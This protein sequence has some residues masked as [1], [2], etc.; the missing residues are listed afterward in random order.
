MIICSKNRIIIGLYKELT[1]LLTGI[2]L[3]SSCGPK[4]LFEEVNGEKLGIKF[5]NQVDQSEVFNILTFEHLYNGGGVAIDDFNND[6]LPDIFFTGNIVN[7]K[8]FLNRGKLE[9]EDISAEAGI[10]APQKWCSGIT[11][12]DINHDGWKDIYLS[13]T[14][15]GREESRRNLLFI[16]QGLNKQGIPEF[17]D[18]ADAYGIADDG[19]SVQSV[20]F[21]FDRDND[22]DLYVL[23]NQLEVRSPNKFY[24]KRL[25][26]SAPHTDRLYRNN[27]DGTFTNISKEAGVQIEGYGLSLNVFDVN[28]DGWLDIYIAND[29]LT[30]DILYVNNQDGTFTDK[31]SEYVKHQSHSSMGSDVA[32]INDDGLPDIL[33]VEMLPRDMTRMKRMWPA[34]SFSKYLNSEKLDYDFQYMRNMVQIN[35]GMDAQGRIKF[36][37]VSFHTGLAA[38]E[39]SWATL[40]NDY[41]AD[42]DKDVFICNGF[43]KDITDMDFAAYKANSTLAYNRNALLKALPEAKV[44]NFFFENKGDLQFEDA[45]ANWGLETVS[46]SNGAAYGDLDR[47]GDLDLVVNNI[48]DNATILINHSKQINYLQIVLEDQYGGSKSIGAKVDL[49]ID[50]RRFS[51]HLMPVR[52]YIS[53]MEPILFFGLGKANQVDSIQIQWADG[54]IQREFEIAANQRM[55]ISYKG[56]TIPKRSNPP[57]PVF[58]DQSH[59]L[60]YRHI[61]SVFSDFN[62]QRLLPRQYSQ[63]GPAV[64]VGDLDGNGEQDLVVGGTLNQVATLLFSQNGTFEA[65]PLA[66]LNPALLHEDMGMLLFDADND[67]DLDLYVVS[68]GYEQKGN[69]IAY[70]DR[71]YVNQGDGNFQKASNRL[72]ENMTSGSCIKG[73]DYDRDGDIDLFVGGRIMPGHYPQPVS[74]FL[75]RNDS[76]GKDDV[77]FSEVSAQVAPALT[78]IGMVTDASWSDFDHDG[79]MDLVLVGEWMAPHFF[80]NNHGKFELLT[81]TGI[82]AKTGWWNSILSGDFDNDGDTDYVCG[83]QG[84]NSLYQA[85]DVHP[86]HIFAKD[87]DRNGGFDAFLASEMGYENG[88][89]YPLHAWDDMLKQMQFLKKKVI[90]YKDY[91]N[92]TVEQLFSADELKGVLNLQARYMKSAYIENLGQDSFAIHPLPQAA[93]LAPIQGML[94]LD[95]NDDLFLDILLVGNNFGGELFGGKNDAL[96]GL[97]LYGDGNG[98]FRAENFAKNGFLVPGDARALVSFPKQDGKHHILAS[99]NRDSLKLFE[100]NKPAKTVQLLALDSW[101]ILELAHGSR[102]VELSYGHAY[103][104]QSSRH[105]ILPE[106]YKKLTIFRS[107]GSESNIYMPE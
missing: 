11:T 75:L 18:E 16:N 38:T 3:L 36:S 71:L 63:M 49:W 56:K 25:D 65:K 99:Q 55:S 106:D 80:R 97:V 81:Q 8:L 79:W 51:Q 2:V 41:D 68:G 102:R 84:T 33:T 101:A 1:F 77:H 105:L 85:S 52:G 13:A 17:I 27:G 91:A 98:N 76:K 19:F 92:S 104:S 74:S 12:V 43:P 32:D 66:N 90:K 14:L 26:G 61:E 37:D 21:D 5:T 9:F 47:D 94:A 28:E 42:G 39:W 20:F 24:F 58:S 82:E 6:G 4:T 62:I 95:L 88:K 46:Y 89:H 59:V 69:T 29:Y 48:N 35:Q 86:I 73:A 40:I 103:L 100:W 44:S 34:G 78:N 72:P 10:E 70:A 22:L 87:F 83:N 53:T 96:N 23:T 31:I 45:S 107:D 30:N 15:Y 93:Q 54:K 57:A 7:N 64:S 50:E 67:Y 60:E